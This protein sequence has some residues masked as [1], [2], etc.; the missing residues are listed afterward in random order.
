[1]PD[2]APIEYSVFSPV[3]PPCIIGMYDIVSVGPFRTRTQLVL[4]WERYSSPAE[5]KPTLS[6]DYAGPLRCTDPR[7]GRLVDI[8]HIRGRRWP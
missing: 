8:Q 4:K 3:L 6:D 7:T 5:S 1:M 2:S